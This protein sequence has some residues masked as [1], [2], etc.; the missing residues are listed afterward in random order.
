MKIINLPYGYLFDCVIRGKIIVT[1]EEWQQIKTY[2]KRTKD[3][4]DYN[5]TLEE[6]FKRALETKQGQLFNIRVS[7]TSAVIKKFADEQTKHKYQFHNYMFLVL[8]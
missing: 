4:L 6:D 7:A 8:N 2:L 1:K 5:F 3:K